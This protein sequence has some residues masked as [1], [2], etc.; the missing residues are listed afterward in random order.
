MVSYAKSV[1]RV[2]AVPGFQ[3]YNLSRNRKLSSCLLAESPSFEFLVDGRAKFTNEQKR[4]WKRP[5]GRRLVSFLQR[6]SRGGFL[7]N[8]QVLRVTVR[9]SALPGFSIH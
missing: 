2:P 8:E 6:T 3:F 4:V 9:F 5:P 1:G 7:A